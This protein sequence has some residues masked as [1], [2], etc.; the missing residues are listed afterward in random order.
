[1]LSFEE[2]HII[3]L[4]TVVHRHQSLSRICKGVIELLG[5]MVQTFSTQTHCCLNVSSCNLFCTCKLRILE[6]HLKL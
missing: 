5:D 6:E 2:I 1:M 3:F 4:Q